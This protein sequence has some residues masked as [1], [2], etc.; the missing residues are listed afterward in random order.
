MFKN[1][2]SQ[3][4]VSSLLYVL[5]LLIGL[6]FGIILQKY[7]G[8][9]N[10][11]REVGLPYPTQ[12]GPAIV[13]ASP[14]VDEIPE[15]YQG[16]LYLFILAGQSNMVGWAPIPAGQK[17]DP[18]IYMFGKDYHWRIADHPI[19]DAFDQVDMV[20]ENRIAGFGPAMDFAF[21]SLERHP[22]IVIGL[23]PCAKNSSGIIQWQRDL[24]DQSLYG[25]CLKRAHAASTMGQLSGI[26]FFQGET[27]AA[28]PVRYPEPVPHPFD[29]AKLFEAFVTD[30]RTD[31][32]APEIP[33]V[34]AQIGPNAHSENVPNWE[35][36]QTQQAS[37]DLPKT[38]VIVTDDL[39]LLD[40]LHFTADSYRIIGRRFAEAYWQLV[41]SE[42]P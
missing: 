12:G 41:E 27:D 37:V 8:L 16:K 40:G 33:V 20:S 28:D 21:T 32:Q 17:T 30:F 18:R 24:S 23:I 13:T 14:F 39:A 26:L 3:R 5:L 9:G 35:A 42:A 2:V 6:I 7:I 22:D 25:S 15:S 34:F 29:W 31:L 10:M 4:P 19:E 11:L 38:A 36:V 1:I